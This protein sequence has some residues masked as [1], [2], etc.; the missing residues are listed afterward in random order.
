MPFLSV[1]I[2]FNA[3]AI[4]YVKLN[5]PGFIKCRVMG[6]LSAEI[7]WF[8]GREK[9]DI[10]STPSLSTRYEQ[11]NGG[12]KIHRVSSI[13]QDLFFCQADAISTGESKEFPIEVIL[14]RKS[15]RSIDRSN[16]IQSQTNNET[17]RYFRGNQFCSYPL[18]FSLCRGKTNSNINL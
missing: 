15:H 17:H 12:L 9:I 8:K 18:S 1:P 14:A 11:R 10:F 13:D 6:N 7:S 3:D 5:L 16:Q 4:Q 2:T